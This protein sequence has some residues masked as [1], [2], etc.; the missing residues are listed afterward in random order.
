MANDNKTVEA[1]CLQCQGTV[2]VASDVRTGEVVTCPDCSTDLEVVE[3]SPLKL[4]LAP[5]AQEDWGE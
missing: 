2:S 1:T 4:E 3:T 5:E